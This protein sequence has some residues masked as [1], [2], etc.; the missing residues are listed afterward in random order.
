ME[1]TITEA[2]GTVVDDNGGMTSSMGLYRTD[3]NGQIILDGLVGTFLVTETKTIEGY[4]IHEETRTQTV[5]INP[6]DTQT[7]TVYN[8]PIGG[9]ELVKVNSADK[10]QRIPNVTFEIREMDGGLVDTVTTDKNGRV[11]L[12]LEDGAYYAVEIESAAG[13]KLDDTPRLFHRGGWQ[14]H[15]PPGGE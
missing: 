6:N 5:V 13:F 8:D 9:V 4:T 7:I 15:H 11:F 1:F 12:P 14:N 10:T 2:D 3:E